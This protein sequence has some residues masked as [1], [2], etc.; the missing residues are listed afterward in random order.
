M[1]VL[2]IFDRFEFNLPKDAKPLPAGAR[3]VTD[4][5][6]WHFHPEYHD[7]IDTENGHCLTNYQP[8]PELVCLLENRIDIKL[9]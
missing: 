4:Y 5:Q 2:R 8:P 9:E 7:W 3:V 6:E 1:R